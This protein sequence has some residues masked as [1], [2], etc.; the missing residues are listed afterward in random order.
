MN[1]VRIEQNHP[2]V[3]TVRMEDIA[4]GWEQSFFL[5][6]DA[7][8]DNPYSDHALER[9]HLEEA[10]ERGAGILDF[11]DLYCAMQGKWDKRA[12]QRQL[13]PELREGG[14]PYL[15]ALVE[16]NARFYEPYAKNW[17]LLSEGNHETAITKHHETRLS[18]RLAE[19]LRIAGSPV[20]LGTYAGWVQFRFTSNGR[21]RQTIRLRYTHG[22]GGGG[23]VTRDVIQT[24]RQ[25]VY[26]G[27]ADILVS[28][29]VH[30]SW[31]VTIRRETLD[32]NGVPQMQDVECIKCPGYKDEHAPGVGFA[33][34]KGRNPKPMGGWWLRFFF[35]NEEVHYDLQRAK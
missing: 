25:M 2:T 27:N 29:H 23:P 8:H 1:G 6:S 35:R 17:V 10:K 32:V 34:E 4:S 15:D 30:E 14:K 22:Y 12:D 33:V 28:G 13:R 19:R 18:E 5:R 21:R 24:N 9:Q 16:Y 31:H 20:R 11:G 3:V 7:H 26:L